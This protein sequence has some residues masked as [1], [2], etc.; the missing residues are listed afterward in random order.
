MWKNNASILMKACCMKT[1][2]HVLNK[3][4]LV[5]FSLNQIAGNAVFRCYFD[6]CH[7]N[8]KSKQPKICLHCWQD[9]SEQAFHL[10]LMHCFGKQLAMW[11][12]HVQENLTRHKNMVFLCDL[13]TQLAFQLWL[14]HSCGNTSLILKH[15]VKSQ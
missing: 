6:S 5:K 10:L 3:L 4:S 12:E 2:V 15:S 8:W 7:K 9:F 13:Y 14:M 11:T 1:Y